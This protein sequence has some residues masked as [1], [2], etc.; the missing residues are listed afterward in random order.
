M[1]LEAWHDLFVASAGSAAALAGLIIVA[2]SVNIQTIIA[3]PSMPSRAGAAIASLVLIVVVSIG[4]LVPGQAEWAYGLEVM[5]FGLAALGFSVDAAVRMLR[6]HTGAARP[7]RARVL[8][9]VLGGIQ[10]APFVVGGALIV[11]GEAAG[12]G[13]IAA[14]I[15]LVFIGSVLSAWVLLVEILR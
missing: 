1:Q 10:I 15:L 2:M 12:L 3:I 6:E 8:N 5:V 9:S 7:L 4:G 14:G 13:W 11:G